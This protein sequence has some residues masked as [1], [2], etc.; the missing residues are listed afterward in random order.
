VQIDVVARSPTYGGPGPIDL[1]GRVHVVLD[2]G[3][4]TVEPAHAAPPR[5][6]L[7][8]ELPD[9]FE[10]VRGY[11]SSGRSQPGTGVRA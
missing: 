10:K 4:C 5:I 2:D 8:L 7:K 3:D 1:L 9:I 6:E 11:L